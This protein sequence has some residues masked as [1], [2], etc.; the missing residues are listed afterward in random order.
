V[1]AD[2]YRRPSR[3][4]IAAGLSA[5]PPQ[6]APEAVPVPPEPAPVPE[7]AYPASDPPMSEV[8][9]RAPL[10]PYCGYLRDALGHFWAHRRRG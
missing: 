8:P 4:E 6:P 2:L 7:L 9:G 3:E 5:A 10:C 1:S